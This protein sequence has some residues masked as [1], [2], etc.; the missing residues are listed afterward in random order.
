MLFCFAWNLGFEKTKSKSV[1]G[2]NALKPKF[3]I[4]LLI[5]DHIV[6]TL[7]GRERYQK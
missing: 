7:V 6:C 4:N 3:I 1:T 5:T 2:L